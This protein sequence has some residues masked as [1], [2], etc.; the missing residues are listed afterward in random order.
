M[1]AALTV[2][3]LQ[4]VDQLPHRKLQALSFYISIKLFNCRPGI[5]EARSSIALNYLLAA[6]P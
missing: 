6:S 1:Q 3:I 4:R 5:D 2:K